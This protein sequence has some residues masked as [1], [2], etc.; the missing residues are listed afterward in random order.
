MKR[1]KRIVILLAVLGVACVATFAVSRYEAYQEEIQNSDEVILEIPTDSVTALSWTI[2]GETLSLHRDG[3]WL[4]DGDEAFPVDGDKISDMLAQFDQFGVSF[5]IENVEDYGQ[6]GLDDPACTIQLTADDQSYEIKLGDF[7]QMDEERYVDIGDGNVYLVTTDPMDSFDVEL[8]DLILNDQIPSFDQVSHITFAGSENYTV[9][10]EEDSGKSYSAD[11]VYFNQEGEPL[12]TS[13]VD[14]YLANLSGVELTDYVTYNA[15][16]AELEEYG[17]TDPEL[18]VTVDYSYTDEDNNEVSDTCVVS[19]ARAPDD[20]A[21]LE[22]A[23]S[24][25]EEDSTNE[26]S[27]ITAYLRVGES[28]IIY[29]IAG[30]DFT[31]LM[32]AG[33]DTLRHQQIFWGDMEDV[34]QI[35]IDLEGETHT[36]DAVMQGDAQIFSYNGEE[37]DLT[38]F[39]D[40]LEALSADRFTDAAAD[41]EEEIRL[42]LH[43][44]SEDFPTVTIRITRYDGSLCLAQVDGESVAL[45]SRADA[46][47]LVE[48][49]QAIVLGQ[50]G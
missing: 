13:L 28:Q 48:A 39:T 23:D 19:V 33:Y 50:S 3:T 41:G 47:D 37:V 44:N 45:V 38:D 21:T 18:T 29:Q 7:S 25:D 16:D 43:L 30:D 34:T 22:S 31:E 15:T 49:V 26:S 5:R 27:S 24:D 35:D 36:I 11:D 46:M 4:Y 2:D 32:D 9:T 10:Y 40:A 17:L 20:R 8:K 1:Y 14:D 12:D 6:Y 42:T